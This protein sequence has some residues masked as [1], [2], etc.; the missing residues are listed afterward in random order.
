MHD[1]ANPPL[2]TWLAT[3]LLPEVSDA[4]DRLRRAPDVLRVA[5]MPDV[6][7]GTDVCVGVALATSTAI[8]PQA[9]GG[10]IGCGMLAVAFDGDAGALDDPGRAV[11]VLAAIGRAVPAR[12]RQ[13]R[14]TIA[15]PPALGAATL[16]TPALEALRRGAGALEFG[17]L[18]GG[19]HFV[20]L[21]ADSDGRLWLMIHSGS[22]AIGPAIRDRH[23]AAAARVK[24][25]LRL[26][27]ATT[28]AGEAY[29]HD[30]AWARQFAEANRLAM[31]E[32]VDRAIGPM[33]GARLDW[34]SL[35][36]TDHNHVVRESHD[37]RA[38]WVHR[39]GA[40]PAG[41][42]VAGVV[43]GSMGTT[44]F[45]VVG[46][47]HPEALASSAHGAGRVMSRSAARCAVSERE[48]RRQMSG[49]CYDE[50][51]AGAL[52]DEAP[53]AYKDVR[54]V[55][56]AQRELARVTRELRPLVTYKGP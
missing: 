50:R 10:D 53:S 51:L 11:D 29:L 37:D 35:I 13:R 42:G 24:H 55:V 25:G 17:T 38:C 8:Y 1:G 30:A 52:R 49:I 14:A 33:V 44:S 21:Q 19:N 3:P 16:S 18:G 28:P 23:L 15:L 7:L 47:G 5:V 27:D 36:A 26:L 43:P 32:E 4:I 2:R 9:V 6:H 45:H 20:E 56:R 34:A 40:M 54:A 12:R 48:L 46:R 31:A 39:K 41:A 22:R